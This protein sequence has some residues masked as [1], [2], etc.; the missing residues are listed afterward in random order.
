M[1]HVLGRMCCQPDNLGPPPDSLLAPA[2]RAENVDSPHADAT[3]L[4]RVM[5]LRPD[6]VDPAWRTAPSISAAG[7]DAWIAAARRQDWPGYVGAPRHASAALGAWGWRREVA[8]CVDVVRRLLDGV[9]ERTIPRYADRMLA[10]PPVRAVTD[11]AARLEAARAARQAAWLR[12]HPIIA[13][14]RR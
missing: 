11:S 9:D 6:L 3:E 14:P 4:S 7:P 1:V 12:A 10:I 13:A 5:V 2:A 8:G